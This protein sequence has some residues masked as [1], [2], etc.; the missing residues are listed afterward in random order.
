MIPEAASKRQFASAAFTNFLAVLVHMLCI[1]FV[2]LLFRFT[3]FFLLV[4]AL[5]SPLSYTVPVEML[6]SHSREIWR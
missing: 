4:S 6:A 1:V 3:P 2:L 5:S